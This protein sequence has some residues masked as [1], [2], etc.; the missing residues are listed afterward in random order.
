MDGKHPVG[1][2]RVLAGLIDEHGGAILSDL[3][4][5][6]QVDLRDLFRD[7]GDLSPKYVLSLVMDLPSDSAFYASRRGG[8]QFRGWDDGRYALV[9]LVN[10][11]HAS[12]YMFQVANSDPKKGKKP[13]LPEPFPIPDQITK[14]KK[15]PKPGSF[16]FIAA[17]MIAAQRKSKEER[18]WQEQK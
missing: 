9:A 1:G 14:A 3:L 6:Y 10:A 5:Y 7:E 2:S 4:H 11:A 12:N 18:K 17:Q 15:A 8:R 13:S 16:A